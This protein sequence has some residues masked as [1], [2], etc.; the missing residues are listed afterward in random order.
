MPKNLN[1]TA[2]TPIGAVRVPVNGDPMDAPSDIEAIVQALL[3]MMAGSIQT[4]TPTGAVVPYAGTAAPDGWLL[5][6]GQAVSRTTYANLFAVLG[7][8]YGVGNSTTTFNLPDLRGRTVV[9][10]G[11]GP[12]LTNRALAST[13]GAEAHA[14][15]IQEMPAHTHEAP[16]PGNSV[17]GSGSFEVPLGVSEG[18]GYNTVD[19]TNAASTSSRGGNQAHNNM[20]PYVALTYIVRI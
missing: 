10:A 12:A 20:P 15:T 7:T 11:Q 14:L 2:P 1:V 8:R 16:T 13:G 3:N 19:Y 6:D 4:A 9:G 18:G 17:A 5:C